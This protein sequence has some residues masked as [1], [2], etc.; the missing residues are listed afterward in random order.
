ML[1]VSEG[2]CVSQKNLRAYSQYHGEEEKNVFVPVK[3]I[4]VTASK[5]LGRVTMSRLLVE[6]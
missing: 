1:L 2:H 6:S 4:Q 3:R 5:K